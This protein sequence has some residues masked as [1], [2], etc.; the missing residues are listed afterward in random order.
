MEASE[1]AVQFCYRNRH[2][3]RHCH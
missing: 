3:S 1:L 2:C